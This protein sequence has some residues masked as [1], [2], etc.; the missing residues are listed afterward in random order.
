MVT[1]SS[2]SV[3]LRI[4]NDESMESMSDDKLEAIDRAFGVD[5]DKGDVEGGSVE[6]L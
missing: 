6:V 1:K 4:R 5:R 3:S 2:K